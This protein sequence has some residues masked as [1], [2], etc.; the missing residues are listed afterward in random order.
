LFDFSI[1]ICEE[2]RVSE[3]YRNTLIKFGI[4]LIT[5]TSK[6]EFER[7]I[8]QFDKRDYIFLIYQLDMIVPSNLTGNYSFFNLH[9]GNMATNRGAHPIIWSLLNGDSETEFTLHK[10]NEKIDQGIIVAKFG[11]IILPDDDAVSVKAKME[12]G[13]LPLFHKLVSFLNLE[14]DG[15]PCNGGIYHKPIQE[16][17]FTLDVFNDSKNEIENKI[18][19]QRQYK[20]AIVWIDDTK[21]YVTNI[22]EWNEADN[23][24]CELKID[25][26]RLIITRHNSLISFEI[27]GYA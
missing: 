8:L 24:T 15:I 1:A 3:T 11:V 19:S 16:K 14:F 2:K 25:G 4:Q 17:D 23:N 27:N 6:F 13:L 22:L 18:R 12:E 20:G 21:H 26:N 9:A 7:I 10:I 5:F